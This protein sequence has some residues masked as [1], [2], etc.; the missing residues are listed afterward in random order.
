MR[1]AVG[2]AC[3]WSVSPWRPA[4]RF[5]WPIVTR[6]AK[7]GI[8][9]QLNALVPALLGGWTPLV[10]GR[11]LGMAA[12]GLVNWAANIASLFMMLSAVLNRVAFPAYSRLQTDPDALAL[13]LRASIRRLSAVLC[14]IIPVVVIVCPVAIPLIFGRR[15]TGAIPL[16][17]WLSLETLLLSLNGLMA[18]AQNAT[19]YAGDRLAVAAGIGLLRWGVGYAALRAFGLAGLGPAVCAV[20]TVE[21]LISAGLVR[22]RQPRCALLVPEMLRPLAVMGGTLTVALMAGFAAK[23]TGWSQTG[24]GLLVFGA[25]VLALEALNRSRPM[26]AELQGVLRLLRP[27]VQSSSG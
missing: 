13:S 20:S 12:L 5:Q 17:Q 19:G 27:K 21:L 3:I 15:W 6:L 2:L 10:V 9:F 16:V 8:P 4:G 1:G 23:H 18:A 24:V 7:F 14:L 26:T 25:A 22:W 11:L